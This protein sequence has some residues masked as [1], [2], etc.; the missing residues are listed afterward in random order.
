[1]DDYLEALLQKQRDK[2]RE[3]DKLFL[4][5]NV[6]QLRENQQEQLAEHLGKEGWEAD[7]QEIKQM[8][9]VDLKQFVDK[10]EDVKVEAPVF[11]LSEE[12]LL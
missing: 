6:R 1:M 11:E 10:A 7:L 8:N 4:E 12:R 9:Q 2:Y 5:G 3:A